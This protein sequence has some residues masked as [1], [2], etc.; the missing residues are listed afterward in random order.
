MPC[1]QLLT[2]FGAYIQISGEECLAGV[3]RQ[4]MWRT[5][6]AE[7]CFGREGMRVTRKF[8]ASPRS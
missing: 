4:R 8:T 7:I 3:Q 2:A 6:F 5:S 1:S